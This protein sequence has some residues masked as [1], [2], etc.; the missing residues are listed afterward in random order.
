M[1]NQSTLMF[2]VNQLQI[3]WGTTQFGKNRISLPLSALTPTDTAHLLS[4]KGCS[5]QCILHSPPFSQFIYGHQRAENYFYSGFASTE[6]EFT[7]SLALQ[8]FSICGQAV[9]ILILQDTQLWLPIICVKLM[10]ECCR[11]CL[12]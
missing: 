9:M 7:Q 4:M 5:L 10:E 12:A 6:A 2:Y 8:Y 11:T 1:Q 3:Y